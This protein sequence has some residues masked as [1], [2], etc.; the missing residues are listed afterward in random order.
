V[1]HTWCTHT[2]VP[3]THLYDNGCARYLHQRLGGV[4]AAGACCAQQRNFLLPLRGDSRKNASRK[5]CNYGTSIINSQQGHMVTV[6]KYC[7]GQETR[8]LLR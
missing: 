5:K 2:V 6:E 7:L 3:A 8:L 4:E 1:A